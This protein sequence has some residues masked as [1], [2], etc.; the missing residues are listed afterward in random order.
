MSAFSFHCMI[1]F[2]E[3]GVE[4]RAPVVL[5]CGHTYVCSTCADRLDRCMECRMPLYT[6]TKAAIHVPHPTTSRYASPTPTRPIPAEKKRLPLPKN[7]VLLSLMEATQL[8]SEQ[9]R[10]SRHTTPTKSHGNSTRS[11]T[12]ALSQDYI[13]HQSSSTSEEEELFYNDEQAIQMGTSMAMGYC[14]TYAVAT[15]E[16][17]T[18]VP[19]LPPSATEATSSAN[20]PSDVDSLVMDFQSGQNKKKKSSL[21]AP[22]LSRMTSTLDHVGSGV[23]LE[24]LPDGPAHPLSSSNKTRVYTLKYGDRIQIVSM[25]D[26]GWARLARGYGFVKAK[27]SELVKV[28]GSMDRACKLE[29]MLHSLA[30]RRSQLKKDVT[31]TE[32]RTIGLMKDLQVSLIADEDITVVAADVF[33][34]T[35]TP[36]RNFSEDDDTSS[37]TGL[38]VLEQRD[39]ESSS[40]QNNDHNSTILQDNSNHGDDGLNKPYRLIR[41]ES[42]QG[43]QERGGGIACYAGQFLSSFAAAGA[44]G[45][46]TAASTFADFSTMT[47]NSTPTTPRAHDRHGRTNAP[48]TS[49]SASSS[50]TTP[51]RWIQPSPTHPPQPNSQYA[52]RM[53]VGARVWREQN[54]VTPSHYVNF[55]TGMSGHKALGSSHTHA[56]QR[57]DYPRQH[58]SSMSTSRKMS[59]HSG[60]SFS[61]FS[62]ST[63]PVQSTGSFEHPSPDRMSQNSNN[64]TNHNSMQEN[65]V[66]PELK[67]LWSGGNTEPQSASR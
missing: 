60:L 19:T 33:E 44:S 55:R 22:V 12:G 38:V 34:S 32:R 1:C 56:Q 4:V 39:N 30:L 41:V 11:L 37:S 63:P 17:L 10:D 62:K 15:K 46:A 49:P 20:N 29:A 9:T 67:Y 7:V 13:D 64:S 57:N 24:S 5:P 35:H 59:S 26:D 2:E 65:L 50:P 43:E 58:R 25:D 42:D 36:P 27:P 6:I 8:A 48:A 21:S 47:P 16:G 40:N 51:S 28:G 52:N 3:F 45:A 14:G 18:I 23:E 66:P 54:G 31:V 61:W 53:S